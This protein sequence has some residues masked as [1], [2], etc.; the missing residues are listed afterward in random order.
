MYISFKY[1]QSKKKQHAP[2]TDHICHGLFFFFKEQRNKGL[3]QSPPST[4]YLLNH[5][6]GKSR[7]CSS[8]GITP[9]S[10]RS[11]HSVTYSATWSRMI[12][13]RGVIT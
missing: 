1:P 13:P 6:I 11:R 2:V 7:G 5:L 12:F 3:M 8:Q 4:P 9:T 10:M